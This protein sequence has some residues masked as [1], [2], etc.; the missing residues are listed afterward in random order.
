MAHLT[1]DN[2]RLIQRVRRLKGQIEGVE[3]MLAAGDDCHKVLQSVAACR[4][5]FHSLTRE[6]IEEHII[7]HIE[8]EPTASRAVKVASREVREILQSYLK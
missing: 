6:L 7:H 4:G 2:K 3:R 8:D 5:A 1:G